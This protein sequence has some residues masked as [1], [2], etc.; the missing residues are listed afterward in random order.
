M[1]WILRA[2]IKR[3]QKSA[4]LLDLHLKAS[5]NTAVI[6]DLWNP[7]TKSY[8]GLPSP[9]AQNER[10]I[11]VLR[12]AFVRIDLPTRLGIRLPRRRSPPV[13]TKPIL[14]SSLGW[15]PVRP[16]PPAVWSKRRQTQN[17]RGWRRSPW[18]ARGR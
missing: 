11:A 18:C 6:H 16:T 10:H 8:E 1:Q 12:D 7:S 14:L 13:G 3:E 4:C 2:G 15:S 9:L 17:G 5:R